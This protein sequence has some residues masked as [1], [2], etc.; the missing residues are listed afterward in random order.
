MRRRPCYHNH[1]WAELYEFGVKFAYPENPDR[2][3]IDT[4]VRFGEGVLLWPDVILDGNVTIGKN[5]E[6]GRSA[7]I[8]GKIKIGENVKIKD[9]IKIT[10][11]GYIGDNSEI[12]HSIHNPKIGANCQIGDAVIVDSI[13][14]DNCVIG[15]RGPAV[16]ERSFL[17]IGMKAKH[18]CGIR[19][20]YI[21]Y[22]VNI[23]E[24]VT[25]ANLAAGEKKKT[26][27][28]SR[29]MIGVAVRIMGGSQ[30]GEECYVADG[31]RVNGI[32]PSRTYFNPGRALKDPNYNAMQSDCS[33][34][35]GGNYLPLNAKHP[36]NP[37]AR[38]QFQVKA[39]YKCG[40]NNG[41]FKQ[42]LKTPQRH[43]GGRTPLA[44]IREE[45]EKALS[46]LLS[47]CK[48]SK[49]IE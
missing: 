46:C 4:S 39:F 19:D 13:I 41:A 14:S 36:V 47:E 35:I 9:Y 48:C 15:T 27:V 25:F 30:I 20:A 45:G 17:G 5:S 49:P 32:I 31:A 6:I 33:W 21:D 24:F 7:I 28:G 29:T 22:E 43:M 38:V 18:A 10:G 3:N 44:C 8:T 42:W 12:G 26:R 37:T 2:Y 11:E 34:Y 23:S 1:S 40:Q 16:I